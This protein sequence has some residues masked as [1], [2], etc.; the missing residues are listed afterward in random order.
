[1]SSSH[2]RLLLAAVIGALA[3]SLPACGG[4]DS[5]G[6]TTPIMVTYGLTGTWA[7][8]VDSVKYLGA[9]GVLVTATAPQVPWTASVGIEPSGYAQ[10]L[11]W[12]YTVSNGQSAMLK[13]TWSRPGYGMR[14]DSSIVGKA[15]AGT[16][17][18][19]TPRLRL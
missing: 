4:K 15:A 11:V 13:A 19:A 1:M 10:A 9:Q 6:S 16:F 12:G 8:R 18:I 2:S 5:T 17:S 7:V 14:G 3:T